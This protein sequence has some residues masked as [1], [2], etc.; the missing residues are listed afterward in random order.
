M[1]KSEILR[2]ADLRK[3]KAFIMVISS[4]LIALIISVSL[5]IG[6]ALGAA[7][8][9]S[10]ILYYAMCHN[11]RLVLWFRRFNTD[12]PN[13]F[14][15]HRIFNKA[16]CGLYSP[17]TI[18]D[19]LFKMSLKRGI[20]YYITSTVFFFG[21]IFVFIIIDKKFG[22]SKYLFVGSIIAIYAGYMLFHAK[23]LGGWYAEFKEAPSRKRLENI[24]LN[25]RYGFTF[26]SAPFVYK[27][28][29]ES[30]KMVV[31]FLISGASA[32]I[33]DVSDLTESIRW[34]LRA[35]LE[36]LP[37]EN[38]ILL[39]RSPIDEQVTDFSN[40]ST[41]RFEELRDIEGI[42]RCRQFTYPENNLGFFKRFQL[43]WKKR[44]E[45]R[46]LI[47]SV[48]QQNDPWDPNKYKLVLDTRKLLS[49]RVWFGKN[50]K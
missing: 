33:I 32:V 11:G 6:I 46:S 29:D 39:F 35:A 12:K 13:I 44:H 16:K 31:R 27:T 8:F 38:I 22:V 7:I 25:I 1:P 43:N 40:N 18:Q 34:E 17:V 3:R 20:I 9:I 10:Y 41:L 26:H 42:A 23:L 30:W 37:P 48:F 14:G 15:F 28:E 4:I 45:L 50:H 5:K 19:P 49:W 47:A 36:V 24:V 21:V 2:Q